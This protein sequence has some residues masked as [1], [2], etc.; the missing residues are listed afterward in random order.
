MAKLNKLNRLQIY[1]R[2]TR[3]GCRGYARRSLVYRGGR[4]DMH[5]TEN[6]Y[7]PPMD[8]LL[9]SPAGLRS[10]PEISGLPIVEWTPAEVERYFTGV[11]DFVMHDGEGVQ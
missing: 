10:W 7:V 8:S 6:A 11:I 2:V 4:V 1:Q 3:D 5:G 9:I